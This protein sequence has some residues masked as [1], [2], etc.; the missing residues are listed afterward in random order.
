LTLGYV[1]DATDQTLLTFKSKR[2]LRTGNGKFEVIGDLTLTCVERT[3]TAA[4][5]EAYV[6]PV[7]GDPVIHSGTREIRFLL[8][9]LMNHNSQ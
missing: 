5:T 4:P 7:Y 8:T 1:P 9:A 3:V 6:G 2:I